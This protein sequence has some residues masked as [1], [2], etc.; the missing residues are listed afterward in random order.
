MQPRV[1]PGIMDIKPYVGGKSRSAG[2]ERVIKLSSNEN[3]YGPS[4]KAM[5]AYTQAS[6]HLHRYPDGSAA[7]LREAIARVYD[8]NSEQ[9]VCGAGSDELIGLL[10]A[11]Y[12]GQGDEVLYPEHAFLMYKI[13]TLG[14]GAT[15][16]SAPETD[17][18]ADVDALLGNV[19]ERTRLVFLANPNNPTGSYLPASEIARL[20]EGLREDIILVIDGA[21]AEYM[22][23]N[24]YT[25]G[26]EWVNDTN[27]VMLRTFS[28][29]YGLP[30]LRVGWGYMPKHI[31][32]VINRIRSPFNVSSAAIAA[33]SAAVEDTHYTDEMRTLNNQ[34][35]SRVSDA[36]QALGLHVYESHGNFIL[37][38]FGSDAQASGANTHML[39]QG[40]IPR[41]VAN[42]GLPTCLR[43]SIGTR[44]END[45]FLQALQ[46]LKGLAA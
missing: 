30:A 43:V 33:A 34:E 9:I 24:D 21:Y 10:I 13:Y 32:D 38:D 22:E 16:V 2:A 40:I 39:Q 23:A 18:H 29:I 41:E 25:D 11:A 27:T 19:S 31:V 35:R 4:P 1:K 36:V 15:P 20:R 5:A 42:Y 28:K 37:V 45:A 26:A 44:E 6:S 14:C 8:L 17:L 3:P 7:A 46:A 12:A